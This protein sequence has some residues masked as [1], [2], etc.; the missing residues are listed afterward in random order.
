[1][2]RIAAAGPDPVDVR[3]GAR[4]RDLR[5]SRGENQSD[6]GRALGL[7]FQQVQKYERGANRISASKLQAIAQHYQVNVGSLFDQAGEPLPDATPVIMS[8]RLIRAVGQM[9]AKYMSTLADVAEAFAEGR[10]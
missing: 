8:S 3:V 4:V 2:P 6:L 5:V 9:P 1:M 10:A 7:T